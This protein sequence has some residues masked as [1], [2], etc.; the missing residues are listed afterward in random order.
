LGPTLEFYSLVSK[1]F[2]RRDLKIWRDADSAAPGIYVHHPTGLYP[3]SPDDIVND[4]GQ[5]RTHILRV[6]GQYV[7]KAMLDSRIIDLSANKVFIKLV[8]GEEVALTIESLKVRNIVRDKTLYSH[9]LSSLWITN[10]QALSTKFRATQYIHE[11]LDAIID[12][13]VQPQAR[14]FREGFSKVF[15]ISDLQAFS[16]DKLDM[17]FGNE[18]EDWGVEMLNEAIKADHDFHSE[19]RAIRELVG[20]MSDFDAFARRDFLQI[21]TGST[22]L[23]IGG[24]FRY[25]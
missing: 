6:V 7:A 10:L 17:L 21:I 19:G 22:K 25:S 8:L 18:D 3:I 14:A 9:D 15:P 4:G 16:G 20:I 2:T 11:V 1:E 23:P 5:K 12:A 24:V 13:S